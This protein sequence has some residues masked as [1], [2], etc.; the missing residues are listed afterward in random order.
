MAKSRLAIIIPAYREQAT[1]GDVVAAAK[2]YGSVLVIDDCSPDATGPR[3]TRAGAIVI[4]NKANLGYDR[5][6]S[7]GFEEAANRGFTHVVTMD[8]DGEH[9]PS[10]LALFRQKLIA[11]SCPLVL[12]VRARKQRFA[13]VIMGWYI[14][15][16]FG[17]SDILCGMKGYDLGLWRANGGFDRNNSIGTELA[18]FGLR[19]GIPF[20]QVPVEGTPRIDQPRF[21][22]RLSANMRILS[23]LGNCIFYDILGK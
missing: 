15:A 7:R 5:T 9:N 8:A 19:S 2:A 16:R 17:V 13:E 6:L 10:T 23:A 12:G 14:L 22:R 11:E 3:G 21:G 18:L 20:V 1:I 4:R